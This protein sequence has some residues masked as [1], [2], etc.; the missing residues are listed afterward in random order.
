MESSRTDAP[1][2]AY[3]LDGRGGA[4]RVGWA[5]VSKWQAG[6]APLWLHL[7]R[8]DPASVDWLRR[9]SG[10]DS[11]VVEALLAEETRPRATA[12]GDGMLV[13]LRGVNLNPGADPEDMISVRVWVEG[14]RVISVRARRLLAAEDVG[15]RLEAGSGATDAADLV[16]DLATGLIDRMSPVLEHLDEAADE[17]EEKLVTG[18]G[19]R[20][21][22]QSLV[23]LRRQAISLRRYLAPQREAMGRLQSGEFPLLTTIHRTRLREINDRVVRFLEDLDAMR[24]RASVIQ[25]ELANRSAEQ[26]NRTMYVL[27]LVAAIML[28]LGFL[29]GLLGINVGGIPGTDNPYSF[30]IVC[31]LLFAIAAAE[32]WVFRRLKWI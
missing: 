19:E 8:R 31:A 30:A 23:R 21:L 14:A 9:R 11:I 3:L 13:I 10:L 28:P 17:I 4:A 18:G 6:D 25:D 27:T 15:D 20:E 26:M 29:T 2:R 1:L 12:H 24:E 16:V 7:D 32:A 5:E 22:R